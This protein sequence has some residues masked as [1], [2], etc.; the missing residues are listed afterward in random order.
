MFVWND[1]KLEHMQHNMQLLKPGITPRE[2][3]EQGHVLDPQYQKQKYGSMMHGVGLCD[4]WP[5]VT[6]PDRW[7]D[8]AFEQPLEAGMVLCVEAL[9]SPEG[10]V[11]WPG[12]RRPITQYSCWLSVS[13]RARRL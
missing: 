10:A 12:K 5:I 8:G 7:Q 11:P 6:Y 2:L 13:P 9:V 4:E 1:F 3:C